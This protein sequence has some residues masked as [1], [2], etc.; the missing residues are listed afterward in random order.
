MMRKV[1]RSGFHRLA[2][3]QH[4]IRALEK[5]EIS[6]LDTDVPQEVAGLVAEVNWLLNVLEQ[7]LQRSRNALGDLAHSL[8]TPL[9]VLQQLP[10]EAALQ[11]QPKICHTLQTQTKRTRSESLSRVI[12]D[13]NPMLRGWY[14]YFKHAHP[15]VFRKLDGFLRRRLRA[16]LRKQEKRPG[17]G[18]CL[19]D[20]QRWTN[21][22][23]AEV[24]LFA[25]YPAW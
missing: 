17:R 15:S 13:L 1:L 2:R 5:G 3:I 9:T 12:A 6:Q 19:A 25:L 7:R 21:A 18:R 4:Q 16:L 14:G 8:K 20:H 10:R 23:F 24:G 11:S 22:F